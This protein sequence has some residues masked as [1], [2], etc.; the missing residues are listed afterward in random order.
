MNSQLQTRLDQLLLKEDELKAAREQVQEI[1]Y[2]KW[3]ERGCP[4]N[5]SLSFWLEAEFEWIAYYYVPD[6]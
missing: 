2:R 3:Q 5:D 4:Q 6:R 1:A